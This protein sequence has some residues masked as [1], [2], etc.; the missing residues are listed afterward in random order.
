M[1]LKD[2]RSIL[3]TVCIPNKYK[4]PLSRGLTLTGRRWQE[5]LKIKLFKA[6]HLICLGKQLFQTRKSLLPLERYQMPGRSGDKPRPEIALIP[7]WLLII[8]CTELVIFYIKKT[9]SPEGDITLDNTD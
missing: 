7:Q 2:I 6:W 8:L 9:K 5:S 4:K 3:P 1:W